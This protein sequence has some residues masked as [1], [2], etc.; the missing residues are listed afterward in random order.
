MIIDTTC[1]LHLTSSEA[2]L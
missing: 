1:A 2:L